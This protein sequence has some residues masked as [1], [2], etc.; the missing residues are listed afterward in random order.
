MRR[1]S[2][3]VVPPMVVGLNSSD[4]WPSSEPD[5]SGR[6]IGCRPKAS[7]ISRTSSMSPGVRWHPGSTLTWPRDGALAGATSSSIR[8]VTALAH[9]SWNA[10]RKSGVA[11]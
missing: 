9:P 4:M 8:A 5:T 1:A 11:T 6:K 3:N 10:P 7:M 2:A